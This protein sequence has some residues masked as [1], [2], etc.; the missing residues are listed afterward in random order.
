MGP[1][2]YPMSMTGR[3]QD[4]NLERY[5]RQFK[6]P[7]IGETGQ[8]RLSAARVLVIGAGGLGSPVLTYLAAALRRIEPSVGEALENSLQSSS[9]PAVEMLLT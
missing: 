7:E 6:L 4:F 9:L 3:S 5:S 1:G 8:A 2:I